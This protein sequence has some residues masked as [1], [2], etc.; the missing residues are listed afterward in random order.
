[1]DD[2]QVGRAYLNAR[3]PL[4]R[5]GEAGEVAEVIAFLASDRAAYV[6]GATL[7]VDGGVTA[8]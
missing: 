5:L 1:M 6:T 2:P 7:P 3:V 8:L 4:G